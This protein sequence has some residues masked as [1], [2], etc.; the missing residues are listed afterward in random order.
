MSTIFVRELL[1]EIPFS[2][3][4]TK[5]IVCFHLFFFLFV[6]FKLLVWK[7]GWWHPRLSSRSPYLK[8]YLFWMNKC[9]IKT[10]RLYWF[11]FCLL[12]TNRFRKA[13]LPICAAQFPTDSCNQHLVDSRAIDTQLRCVIFLKILRFPSQDSSPILSIETLPETYFAS[14]HSLP[15]LGRKFPVT[16][17]PSDICNSGWVADLWE[18][19]FCNF[20]LGS[21]VAWFLRIS[22]WNTFP[23]PAQ[24]ALSPQF[25][26]HI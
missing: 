5:F 21:A 8:G 12:K 25:P 14:P 24:G 17:W 23:L 15:F 18:H 16:S 20:L 26:A 3:F 19:I 9:L 13:S 6:C 10:W 1:C 2:Y 22:L 4:W 11:S 7:W